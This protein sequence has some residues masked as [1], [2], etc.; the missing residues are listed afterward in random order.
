MQQETL[1]E[2]LAVNDPG[3]ETAR[4]Y[5][6]Q[7]TWAAIACCMLLDDTQECSEVFCEHH[8]DVLIKLRNGKYRGLQ[9]KTRDGA[10]IPWKTS[11]EAVKGALSRFCVLERLFPGQ[12]A[13]F[14][15]LTNH[16][17]FAAKNGKDLRHVLQ[18][19]SLANVV[20]DLP[21]GIFRYV[22]SVAG[23]AVCS[24]DVAFA[25]LKKTEADDSLP[26]LA[27]VE[28]R[29]ISALTESWSRATTLSYGALSKGSRR[30]VAECCRA[31]SLAHQDVLP[32]Y[33]PATADPSASELNAR[34]DGKRFDVSRLIGVLEDGLNETHTL[35]GNP[36]N[37]VEPGSGDRGLLQKKLEAGGFSAVSQNSAADLRDKADYLG[38]AWTRKYGR[39]SGLQRHAHIRSLVLSDAA[40]AFES[41][42]ADSSPI[43][44]AMLRSLRA[45]LLER[46]ANGSQLYDCSNEH[47]EG[48][49]Y[50]LS[51]EC[52]I[53]WSVDRPWET[54]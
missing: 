31:A 21:P 38:F 44:V 53:Q 17:L 19:I 22:Q 16:Q 11:D 40:S 8:E 7:W 15:F 14:R 2:T 29:L 45:R 26:K 50:A 54:M 10:Q 34:I 33:L 48:F 24:D 25:A 28:T 30:L 47:L 27:D 23:Q 5:R 12:F 41:V 18:Q 39:E 42:K 1:A 4:R 46:R 3:D 51:S 52:L 36:S 6:Y 9:V 32:A 37:L 43:G 13:S 20:S 49:A 35:D